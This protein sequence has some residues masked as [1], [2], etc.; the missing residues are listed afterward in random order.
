MR[1]LLFLALLILVSALGGAWISGKLRH[2]TPPILAP[3]PLPDTTPERV[4]PE[5]SLS[6]HDLKGT[7]I[8]SVSVGD[9]GTVFTLY[10]VGDVMAYDT[11]R[12]VFHLYKQESGELLI[13]V[14]GQDVICMDCRGLGDLE[15]RGFE[16]LRPL[17]QPP[18]PAPKGLIQS[19]H[20]WIS[21]PPQPERLAKKSDDVVPTSDL[22]LVTKKGVRFAT[23]GLTSTGDPAIAFTDSFGRVQLVWVQRAALGNNDWQDLG[24]YDSNGDLLVSL[25]LRPGK[26]AD[27]ILYDYYGLPHSFDTKTGKLVQSA[28]G[29]NV[30]LHPLESVSVRP[31]VLTDIRHQLVW[32]A[33]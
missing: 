30:W 33:P 13:A 15:L 28:E 22:R 14:E 9:N 24:A 21:P 12:T 10:P 6:L 5:Q 16:N 19:I 20:D 23:L 31:V 27:L 18:T 17:F 26:P 4:I 2:D 7:P 11:G 8:G 32:K 29:A 3:V 1:N 25:E